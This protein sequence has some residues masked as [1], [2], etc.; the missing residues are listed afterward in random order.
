[1]I[2]GID[3][4]QPGDPVK[5]ARAILTALAA[6]T[7]PLRLPLGGDAVDGIL[8]H[9]RT[10]HDE[11]RTWETLSRGTAFATDQLT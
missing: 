10:V 4:T 2:K 11:V 1:M 6:D 7:V 9:L 5:A 3:G 8:D